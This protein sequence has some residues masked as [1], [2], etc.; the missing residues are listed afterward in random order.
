MTRKK[1]FALT[2]GLSYGIDITIRDKKV[3]FAPVS[4]FQPM[5]HHISSK[6]IRR[7]YETIKL[8]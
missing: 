3:N 4:I 2:F 5:S 1:I 7:K 8:I 6:S